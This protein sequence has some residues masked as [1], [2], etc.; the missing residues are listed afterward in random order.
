MFCVN[1]SSRVS[2]F[3]KKPVS[4]GSPPKDRS[5]IIVSEESMGDVVHE[6]VRS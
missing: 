2:H 6:V 1:S 5:V 4:G 3:G